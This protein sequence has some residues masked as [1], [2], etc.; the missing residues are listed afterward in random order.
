MNCIS[1][2]RPSSSGIPALGASSATAAIRGTLTGGRHSPRCARS[3]MWFCCATRCRSVSVASDAVEPGGQRARRHGWRTVGAPAFSALAGLLVLFALVAPN[4][5]SRFSMGAFVRIPV[6]GLLLVGL[7]LA[8][9]PN[10]R[11]V[12]AMIVGPALGL[13]TIM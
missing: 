4:Q 12:L 8:L 13:V 9:R 10:G 1:W 6:E 2:W 3:A 7:V 11:R 5:L